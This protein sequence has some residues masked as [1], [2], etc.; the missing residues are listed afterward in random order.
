MAYPRRCP[1]CEADYRRDKAHDLHH[2]TT[3]SQ[4][5]GTPSRSRPWLPGRVLTLC[6]SACRAEY[7]WDYFAGRRADPALDRAG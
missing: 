3:R 7:G 4:A 1:L 2:T 6:C 5:G